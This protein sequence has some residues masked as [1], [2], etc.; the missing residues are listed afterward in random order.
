MGKSVSSG[1]LPNLNGFARLKTEFWKAT[2]PMTLDF[3]S[4]MP[5]PFLDTWRFAGNQFPSLINLTPPKFGFYFIAISPL[6]LEFGFLMPNTG[7][8]QLNGNEGRLAL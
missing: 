3:K 6:C 5:N 1:F 2:F 7:G 8:G 4:C